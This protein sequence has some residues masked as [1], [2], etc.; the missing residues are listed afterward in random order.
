MNRLLEF[1]VFT[2]N[3]IKILRLWKLSKFKRNVCKKLKSYSLI[4]VKDDAKIR[5]R[6][7]ESQWME[8]MR[9]C[10]QKWTWFHLL[11]CGSS[12]SRLSETLFPSPPL[13]LSSLLRNLLIIVLLWS[14]IHKWWIYRILNNILNTNVI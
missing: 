12:A 2:C 11:R 13:S 7:D 14:F 9:S 5:R 1:E 10:C 4:L 8:K 3:Q 6:W